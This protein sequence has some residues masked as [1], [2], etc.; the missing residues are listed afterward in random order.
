MCLI[1]LALRV[2]PEIPL[3]VAANRDE[4]LDRPT[5]PARFWPDAPR[6]LAGRDRVGGGTWLG[7]TREGRFAALTNYR[8][9]SEP[10]SGKESRGR[11]VRDYL[12]DDFLP[13][14][15]LRRVA[16]ERDRYPGFNLLVGNPGELWYYSNRADWITPVKPGIH[17]VSNA[18]LNTPWTKV[19][20]GKQGLSDG[21]N[22]RLRDCLFDVLADSEPAPDGELPDTG[23]G[24][25]LERGLSPV[26]IDLPGY[27][28][29]SSTVLTVKND[30]EVTFV[31][32]TFSG[33]QVVES[34]FRFFIEDEK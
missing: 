9:P 8:D 29:R 1:L 22:G 32:R 31:E 4:F 17:G 18:F 12:A 5:D 21:L 23:V 20:R 16:E 11:L 34:S 30:G 6:I 19:V 26:R 10:R 2:R 13:V 3:I 7:V 27:G 25:E 15:Y 14:E 24:L 28:T 33:D